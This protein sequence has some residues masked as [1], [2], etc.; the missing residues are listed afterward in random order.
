MLGEN[1][2]TIRS[3]DSANSRISP[4]RPTSSGSMTQSLYSHSKILVKEPSKSSI[5]YFI[6][7]RIN[8]LM[9]LAKKPSP[10]S[11]S[12]HQK[13]TPNAKTNKLYISIASII[14]YIVFRNVATSSSHMERPQPIIRPPPKIT[15]ENEST[16]IQGLGNA[17]ETSETPNKSI[18][19]ALDEI[20]LAIYATPDSN[21]VRNCGTLFDIYYPFVFSLI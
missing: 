18:S 19:S 20:D 6:L 10:S 17:L 11:S 5:C 21:A 9:I 2:N 16:K 1:Y 15:K 3:K 4:N 12:L 8:I 13:N 14:C 7:N